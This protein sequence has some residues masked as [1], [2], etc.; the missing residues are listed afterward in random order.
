MVRK[1]MSLVENVMQI[2]RL[3]LSEKQGLSI[4]EIALILNFSPVYLAKMM[5]IASAR[6]NIIEKNGKYYHKNNYYEPENEETKEV[7]E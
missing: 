1:R 4:E 7:K 2:E 6:G 5:K 3:L